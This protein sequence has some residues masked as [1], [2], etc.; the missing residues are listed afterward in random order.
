MD[1][2]EYDYNLSITECKDGK[3]K[4]ERNITHTLCNAKESN[5]TTSVS[6][7]KC[8]AGFYLKDNNCVECEPGR[9]E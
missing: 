9:Y 1:C 7:D 2:N 3:S 6:C 5:T 4:H 8:K